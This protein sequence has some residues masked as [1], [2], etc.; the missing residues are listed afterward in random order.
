M[1]NWSNSSVFIF[2]F[3]VFQHVP[4]YFITHS[5]FPYILCFDENYMKMNHIISYHTHCLSIAQVYLNCVKTIARKM[6]SDWN[7]NS[8]TLKTLCTITVSDW[9]TKTPFP[10]NPI[11]IS[12]IILIN[13][14]IWF[15][16]FTE[17]K[18]IS[19]NFN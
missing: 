4:C 10:G 19:C 18:R 1:I 8:T 15:L 14:I 17:C 6:A 5:L 9:K 7:G 11:F 12:W 16:S 2:A 3:A 13:L